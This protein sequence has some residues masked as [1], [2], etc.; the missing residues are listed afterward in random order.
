M[1][2]LEGVRSHHPDN[3]SAMTNQLTSQL[4]YSLENNLV[5]Q[6]TT[7]NSTNSSTEQISPRFLARKTQENP[8]TS[9][10]TTKRLCNNSI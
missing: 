9:T 10:S 6:N 8:F 3:F 1:T 4:H 7:N 2:Q 5:E